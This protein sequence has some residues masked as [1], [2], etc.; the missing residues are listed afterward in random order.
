MNLPPRLGSTPSFKR[1]WHLLLLAAVAG[2]CDRDAVRTYRVPKEKPFMARQSSEG[3]SAPQPQVQW[4]TPPGWKEE[5]GSGM[6]VAKFSVPGKDGQD[7]EVSIIPLPDISA[8]KKD[9]VKLW[10]EQIHLQPVESD[11]LSQAEKV[12]MNAGAAELFDMVSTESMIQG[13]YKMRIL[14][15]M[16]SQGPT[17]WF[18]KMTGEDRLVQEQKPAFLEFLKS[19]TFPAPSP[20][21]I[22][23]SPHNFLG[24]TPA[25]PST[26]DDSEGRPKPQWIVPSDWK[27][28]P[29]G[30]MVL[31]RF[32]LPGGGN[33]KTEVT[34]SVFPGETGGLLANVN[35]WRRQ[36]G[37]PDIEVSQL[38]K[39]TMPLDVAGGKATLVDVSGTKSGQKTRLI[40]VI[41]PKAG[42]TWFYK[43]IGDEQIA[44]QQK[45]A[46]FKFVQTVHYPD[47]P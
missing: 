17:T 47:A 46:F 27:E 26:A 13:K 38:G 43:L 3:S 20:D 35:R 15:A 25:T 37:Q 24:Q 8:P 6:K 31:A 14:V 36:V 5:A 32:L 30:Q 4:V 44:E 1:W 11:F 34:I 41:V 28:Q 39:Q 10:R 42:E 7:A 12:E 2:G 19:I 22:A 33:T 16:L 18:F 21:S 23:A 40:G 9:I 29:P 45:T